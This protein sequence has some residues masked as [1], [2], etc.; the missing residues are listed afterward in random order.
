MFDFYRNYPSLSEGAAASYSEFE[1]SSTLNTSRSTALGHLRD[2]G[3][4]TK[5]ARLF[6]R[7][8]LTNNEL[9]QKDLEQQ[10]KEI[11]RELKDLKRH[12]RSQK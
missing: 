12:K 10:N 8:F 2:N 11:L 4:Q 1:S 3:T 7:D 5:Q 6:D 9:K